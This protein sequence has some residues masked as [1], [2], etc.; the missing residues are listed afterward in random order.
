MAWQRNIPLKNE[1]AQPRQLQNQAERE[2]AIVDDTD[3]FYA[4]RACIRGSAIGVQRSPEEFERQE[5]GA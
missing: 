2:M 5:R 4:G 1:L 3:R